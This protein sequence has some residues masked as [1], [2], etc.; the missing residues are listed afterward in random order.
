MEDSRRE[1]IMKLMEPNE[2][3]PEEMNNYDPWRWQLFVH[4]TTGDCMIRLVVG[5]FVLVDIPYEIIKDIASK[6][7][8]HLQEKAENDSKPS[9]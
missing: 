4:E 8:K 7:E 5:K 6:T 1:R 3:T 2:V 9:D